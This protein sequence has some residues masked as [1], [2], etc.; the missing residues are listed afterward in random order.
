[1]WLD[2][3]FGAGSEQALGQRLPCIRRQQYTEVRYRDGIAI[4]VVGGSFGGGLG[5]VR[6]ELV[7]EEVKVDPVI[8]CAALG[9]TEK[10]A[11]ERTGCG[12]VVNRHGEMEA[13]E[14][15]HQLFTLAG[16][17]CPVRSQ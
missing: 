15:G 8:G 2:H 16:H 1:M 4:D 7:A 11:I 3:E 17:R 13:V 6:D 12:Q 5:Q 14:F 10:F 9:A